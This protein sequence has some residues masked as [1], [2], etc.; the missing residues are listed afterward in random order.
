MF[1]ERN[2]MSDNEAKAAALVAEAKKKMGS[3]KG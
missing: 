2:K 3:S 1:S